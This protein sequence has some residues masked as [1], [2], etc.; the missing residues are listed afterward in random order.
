MKKQ[1]LKKCTNRGGTHESDAKE[2]KRMKRIVA[3]LL[4]LCLCPLCAWTETAEA[5]DKQ[6]FSELMCAIVAANQPEILWGRYES[7][8]FQF[9][10]PAAPDGYD[11]VWQ[12][13]DAYYQSY[14]DLFAV[15]EKDQVY[16]RMDWE[17]EADGPSIVA[18]YDYSRY[19]PSYWFVRTEED[20]W[21]AEHETPVGCDE[22][23]GLL[24]LTTE[25]DETLAQEAME[26]ASREYA[27][28]TV[29]A[30]LTVD[31]ETYE[32]V[33]SCV[34]VQKDGEEQVIS[35]FRVVCDQ[36]APLAC[37]VL[38]AAIERDGMKTMNVN[39]IVDPGTEH[40][41]VKTITVPAN[42][43]CY[44]ICEEPFVFFYDQ[45]QTIVS[46]WD[47]MSDLTVYIYTNPGEALSQHFQ[48][49]YDAAYPH[50]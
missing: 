43:G 14:A 50:E 11:V 29:L 9:S 36:T 33:E 40:E 38:R 34:S 26:G 18:G 12:T 15:W 28:E 31:A 41:T 48:E 47:R 2:E 45:E 23:D 24:I 13:K 35:F 6:S 17:Q 3:I 32:I 8:T 5:P 30:H 46:G 39:Y 10:N 44:L 22:K 4:I 7:L 21:K 25:Y 37:R 27:G 1:K 16:C 20:L 49:L 19:Y 42:T